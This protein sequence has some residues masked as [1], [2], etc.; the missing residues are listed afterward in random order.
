MI[1]MLHRMESYNHHAHRQMR[2]ERIRLECS[3]RNGLEG[4]YDS[5][6][7]NESLQSSRLSLLKQIISEGRRCFE[8]KMPI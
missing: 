4:Y 5:P 2:A 6:R 7:I 1:L 3:Y 8:I